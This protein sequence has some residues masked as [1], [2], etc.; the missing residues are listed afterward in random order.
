MVLTGRALYG[1]TMSGWQ[2]IAVLLAAC[3]VAAEIMMVRSLPLVALVVMLGYPPYFIIKRQ[4]RNN[5]FFSVIAENL[6]L[7]VPAIALLIYQGSGK[8]WNRRAYGCQR[9]LSY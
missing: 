8:E 1:E 9:K 5:A 4:L 6:C 2:K 3:G 7:L